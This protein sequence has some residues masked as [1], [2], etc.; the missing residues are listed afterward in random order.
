MLELIIMH[1]SLVYIGTR[2]PGAIWACA[3]GED[4]RTG[5]DASCL[6]RCR[7]VNIGGLR[8]GVPVAYG[9]KNEPKRLLYLEARVAGHIHE[10][11]NETIGLAP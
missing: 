5:E 11:A 1:L 7:P 4:G 8:F 10:D 2:H 6:G 3:G 9:L